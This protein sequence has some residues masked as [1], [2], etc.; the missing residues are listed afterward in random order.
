MIERKVVVLPAPLRP[1][2]VTTS[3]SPTV[4]ETPCKMW[5]SP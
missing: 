1:M 3:P 2:S 5:A 4:S